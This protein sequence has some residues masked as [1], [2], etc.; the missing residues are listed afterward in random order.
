MNEIPIP[1]PCIKNCCLDEK[2]ICR[3][4]F[5][6][7]EE[8]GSWSAIDNS[9]RKTIILNSLQRRSEH[10]AQLRLNNGLTS[11]SPTTNR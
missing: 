1:S 4:C 11:V 9:G 3:G 8:I 2:N 5:R 10:K 6:S 7:L